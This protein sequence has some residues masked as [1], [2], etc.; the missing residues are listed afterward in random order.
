[1]NS[2]NL[3]TSM[4]A[5]LALSACGQTNSK[6]NPLEDYKDLKTVPK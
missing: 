1:M 6:T 5:V 3:M 2:K 4:I